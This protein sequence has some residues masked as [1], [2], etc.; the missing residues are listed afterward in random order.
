[1][2][3]KGACRTE[4]ISRRAGCPARSPTTSWIAYAFT[5]S[6]PVRQANDPEG[7]SIRPYVQRMGLERWVDEHPN[8]ISYVDVLNHLVHAS[9]ILILGST[10]ISFTLRRKFIRRSRPSDQSSR[11][12][13]NKST[14]WDCCATS[15][16]GSV[17]TL[18]ESRLPRPRK[19]ASAL[20]TFIQA[21]RHPSKQFRSELFEP[22]SARHSARLLAE[23]LSEHWNYFE[24][25]GR[26]SASRNRGAGQ[27]KR[28]LLRE[29]CTS[30]Q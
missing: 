25:R 17:T 14:R 29:S 15:E 11:S 22:Y 10:E 3:P 13:M 21:P 16:A 28:R 20:S 26:V 27:L 24:K 8:R 7:Y 5:S 4:K 2:W 1:M 6:A 19:L 23:A 9:A 30:P 18:T 12:C